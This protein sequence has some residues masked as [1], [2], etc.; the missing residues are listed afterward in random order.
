MTPSSAKVFLREFY[1]ALRNIMRRAFYSILYTRRGMCTT[2][3][4]CCRHVYLRNQG[5]LVSSFD[6][7]LQM[8]LENK[9]YKRFQVKGRDESGYLYFACNLISTDNKCTDYNKRPLLCR[10]YPD[11]GMIMYDAVP[12]ED[13]GFY[14]VNRFTGKR[15]L[16]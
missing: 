11:L 15:V 12:K 9:K 13:C 1:E 6:E 4:R 10:A 2:C 7:Y 3:G 8:L 5:K 16:S 14:F